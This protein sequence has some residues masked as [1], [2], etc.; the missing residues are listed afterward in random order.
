M[1]KFD[2]RGMEVRPR[3]VRRD[4]PA[5]MIR[6][7]HGFIVDTAETHQRFEVLHR[8][9]HKFGAVSK[10]A[11]ELNGVTRRATTEIGSHRG[12]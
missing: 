11:V 8:N 6:I 7:E 1:T 3:G 5:K 9:I 2:L 4:T 10:A 12:T